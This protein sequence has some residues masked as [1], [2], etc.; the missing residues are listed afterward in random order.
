[1]NLPD[2][3]EHYRQDGIT[4]EHVNEQNTTTG[5]WIEYRVNFAPVVTMLP[6]ICVCM[7]NQLLHSPLAEWLMRQRVRAQL[8]YLSPPPGGKTT[9]NDSKAQNRKRLTGVCCCIHVCSHQHIFHPPTLLH[10]PSSPTC[11]G[12]QGMRSEA[13]THWYTIKLKVCS[14]IMSVYVYVVC[15]CGAMCWCVCNECVVFVCSVCMCVCV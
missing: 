2:G 3:R 10:L 9:T 8:H 11:P 12:D 13:G 15:V 6:Y 7:L 4:H 5:R 1:V 14:C